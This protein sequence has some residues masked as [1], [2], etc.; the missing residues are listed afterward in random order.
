MEPKLT[1]A[2]V[3]CQ[4]ANSSFPPSARYGITTRLHSCTE[5]LIVT[6]YYS[7]TPLASTNWVNMDPKYTQ[8]QY[9]PM[10]MP[11]IHFV[12]CRHFMF[13]TVTL[14]RNQ[15]NSQSSHALSKMM[16]NSSG[17]LFSVWACCPEIV[18]RQPKKVDL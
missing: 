2:L 11:F 16:G 8:A 17:T 12:I 6:N 7:S 1:F 14:C 18:S 3:G 15:S 4:T 13:N 9:P 5:S 10:I